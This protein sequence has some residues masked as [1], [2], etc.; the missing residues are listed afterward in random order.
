MKY[1]LQ[2][3]LLA[4]LYIHF[5][6]GTFIF[7]TLLSTF[8]IISICA[9]WATNA[10]T[11][12]GFLGLVCYRALLV[13]PISMTIA[14]VFSTFSVFGRLDE[15]KEWI[16]MLSSG[17]G[18]R[19]LLYSVVLFFALPV[20][21]LCIY[22]YHHVTPWSYTLIQ[23]ALTQAH[24][25]RLLGLIRPNHFFKISDGIIM[26]T[27]GVNKQ[28]RT[29][30]GV[31]VMDE[32]NKEQ[33]LLIVAPK[34]HIVHT[35]EKSVE[36]VLS[37]GHMISDTQST[38][39]RTL[40]FKKLTLN[41]NIEQTFKRFKRHPSTYYFQEL[42][43]ITNQRLDKYGAKSKNYLRYAM[44]VHRGFAMSAGILVLT[45]FVLLFSLTGRR[46]PK[47]FSPMLQSIVLL[48]VIWIIRVI[49]SSLVIKGHMAA[50]AALWAPN[51][52]FAGLGLMLL[53]RKRPMY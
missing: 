30:S 5:M 53:F 3:H 17:I 49:G 21:T 18:L 48:L 44:H 13:F 6:T 41:T 47:A 22:L 8:K 50:W 32:R 15:K 36:V 34:G 46:R 9:M 37:D 31:Y 26:T 29:L 43:N 7:V 2:R 27:S 12:E 1:R 51:V 23:Q 25:E 10:I 33:P 38:T 42:V 45:F 24:E 11:F 19:H 39:T 52:L 4:Q 14:A 16:G 35:A 20:A 28:K 40:G